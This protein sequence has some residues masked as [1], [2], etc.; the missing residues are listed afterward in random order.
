MNHE[1]RELR[2]VRI[3]IGVDLFTE[4]FLLFLVHAGRFPDYLIDLHLRAGLLFN[5]LEFPHNNLNSASSKYFNHI[6]T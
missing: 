2:Q 6:R 5:L 3:V 1:Q 4:F